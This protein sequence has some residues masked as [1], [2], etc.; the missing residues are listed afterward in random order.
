MI[1]N[2]VKLNQ[3]PTFNNNMADMYLSNL[4]SVSVYLKECN[5][6]HAIKFFFKSQ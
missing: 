4:T 3:K 2:L 6:H 1:C 5:Q